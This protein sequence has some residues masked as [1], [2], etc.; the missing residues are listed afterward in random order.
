MYASTHRKKK[1]KIK[2]LV[3]KGINLKLRKQKSTRN[4]KIEENLFPPTPYIC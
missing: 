4:F 2:T 3:V 1:K